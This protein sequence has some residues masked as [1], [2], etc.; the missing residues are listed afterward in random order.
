LVESHV[1]PFVVVHAHIMNDQDVIVQDH[2]LP[3]MIEQ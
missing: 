2:D 1:L 3:F